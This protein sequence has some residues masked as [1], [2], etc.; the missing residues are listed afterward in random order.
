VV[1]RGEIW[2]AQ[3]PEPAGSEPGYRRPVLVVQDDAFNASRIATVIVAA[4]TSNLRLADAPGN[5]RIARRDSGLPKASVVNVSQVATIP[6][7]SLTEPAGRLPDRLL[8]DVDA[9]L[10]LALGIP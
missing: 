3:L 10:R 7:V 6:K 5:V 2:W 8:A 9:G 4:M 1:K